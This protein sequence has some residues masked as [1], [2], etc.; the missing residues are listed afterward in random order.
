MDSNLDSDCDFQQKY[1]KALEEQ[2]VLHRIISEQQDEIQKLRD[3]HSSFKSTDDL[4]TDSK[5][6]SNKR[7]CIDC[8][9]NTTSQ[10]Y[11]DHERLGCFICKNCYRKRWRKRNSLQLQSCN[12]CHTTTTNAWVQAKDDQLFCQT[13]DWNRSLPN[14]PLGDCSACKQHTEIKWYPNHTTGVLC[15]ACYGQILPTQITPTNSNATTQQSPQ[16]PTP[17]SATSNQSSGFSGRKCGH[18]GVTRT[19]CW[20]KDRKK[21]GGHVCR[22]CY[23]QQNMTRMDILPDGTTQRRQCGTCE[24]VE[25]T[26]WYN[27]PEI[28]GRFNCIRC[29]QRRRLRSLSSQDIKR[30]KTE[31]TANMSARLRT[32]GKVQE[33]AD[34]DKQMTSNPIDTTSLDFLVNNLPSLDSKQSDASGDPNFPHS[35]FQPS[36]QKSNAATVNQTSPQQ[37]NEKRKE[38]GFQSNTQTPPIQSKR[39]KR[40]EVANTTT[41]SKPDKIEWDLGEIAKIIT[42]EMIDSN[43]PNTTRHNSSTPNWDLDEL[44]NMISN[45]TTLLSD[46][47]TQFEPSTSWKVEKLEPSE[48]V[49]IDAP[50]T[51]ERTLQ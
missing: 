50:T 38:P 21:L 27:D 6:L 7:S 28:A 5:P 26:S 37:P 9:A 25:T 1:Y 34:Q 43:I 3:L 20:Y 36:N 51:W 33:L 40:S 49:T 15:A 17:T 48:T 35:E 14:P 46:Q 42:G 2:V 4:K 41:Q 32:L 31:T 11:N 18:C 10:W 13:C 24:S 16:T 44:A 19:S 29:Y 8:C 47:T 30:N 39:V 23:T 45:D 22:K 12:L